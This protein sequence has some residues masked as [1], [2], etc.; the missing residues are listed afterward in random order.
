MLDE[1]DSSQVVE[2]GLEGPCPAEASTETCVHR[3]IYR[4]TAHK[5][6]IHTHS[7]YAVALS[8]L[9]D[10]VEPLD[11]EGISFMGSLPVVEGDFGTEKLAG[12]VAAA[13]KDRSACIALGHGVFAAG[14]SLL[15]AYEAA[16]MAEHSSQV[17]FLVMLAEKLF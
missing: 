8:L 7:P 9:E 6:V 15:E 10:M 5:S 4:G 17:R 12:N 2:V 3:A 11:S 16:C 14:R 13:L 1:L